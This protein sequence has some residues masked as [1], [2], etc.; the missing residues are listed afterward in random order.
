MGK[1]TMTGCQVCKS[2]QM[3]ILRD[4]EGHPGYTGSSR[5]HALVR[6]GHLGGYRRPATH[7][8]LGTRGTEPVALERTEAVS[9][10]N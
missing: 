8:T 6:E 5:S 4:E 2:G 7:S 9:R 1:K 3:P 10:V